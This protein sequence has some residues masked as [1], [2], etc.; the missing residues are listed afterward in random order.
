MVS[1]LHALLLI[2]GALLVMR[3]M[4]V[5]SGWLVRFLIVVVWLSL[6]AIVLCQVI[7]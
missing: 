1:D 5:V 3:L 7:R 6:L 4:L 2:L